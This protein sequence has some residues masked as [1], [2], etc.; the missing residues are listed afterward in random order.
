MRSCAWNAD[1]RGAQFTSGSPPDLLGPRR[2]MGAEAV[3]CSRHGEGSARSFR[4][5]LASSAQ[6][7]RR[8]GLAHDGA[9]GGACLQ[10]RYA[11]APIDGS[12]EA[13]H[14]WQTAFAGRS[15]GTWIRSGRGEGFEERSLWQAIDTQVHGAPRSKGACEARS[16]FVVVT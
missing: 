11:P 14:R 13:P 16:D 1:C 4:A 9:H 2:R 15:G 8:L 6:L 10:D 3:E 5:C 7:G 12:A